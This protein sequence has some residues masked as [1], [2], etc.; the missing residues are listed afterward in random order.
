MDKKTENLIIGI[1]LSATHKSAKIVEQGSLFSTYQFLYLIEE[2]PAIEHCYFF[3][4]KV[5]FKY[6]H[7]HVGEPH[8]E[9][10]CTWKKIPFLCSYD[11]RIPT[12]STNKILLAHYITVEMIN[13][14]LQ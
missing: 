7:A 13:E 6:E 14:E 3:V 4:E 2:K 10:L 1:L 9:I 5:I 11:V 8:V 12:R